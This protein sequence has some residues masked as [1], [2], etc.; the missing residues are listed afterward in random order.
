MEELINY[1]NKNICINCVNNEKC[2]FKE[3]ISLINNKKERTITVMCLK[4][5]KEIEEND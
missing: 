1:Y 4:Y 5:K 3:L 2:I